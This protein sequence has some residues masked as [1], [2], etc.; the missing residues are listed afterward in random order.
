M[1]MCNV[2]FPIVLGFCRALGYFS[3]TFCQDKIHGTSKVISHAP[4]WLGVLQTCL[5]HSVPQMIAGV[6]GTLPNFSVAIIDYRFLSDSYPF[7]Q[8]GPEIT[9]NQVYKWNLPVNKV[10]QH[11]YNYTS[12]NFK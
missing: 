6:P 7:Y 10:Y 11:R 8:A 4:Q 3:V 5:F 1:C 9:A 12:A 2:L